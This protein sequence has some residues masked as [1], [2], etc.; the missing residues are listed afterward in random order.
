[1]SEC[2]MLCREL[3]HYP[4]TVYLLDEWARISYAEG[5]TRRSARLLGASSALRQSLGFPAPSPEQE[6]HDLE[7]TAVRAAVT[8]EEY[9]KEVSA[10]TRMSLEQAIDY[11]LQDDSESKDP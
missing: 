11:A 6:T 8:E 4:M 2:L 7:M 3:K 1:M 5:R 9:A 10:G